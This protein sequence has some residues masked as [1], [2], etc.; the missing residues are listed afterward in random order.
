MMNW[1][2]NNNGNAVG[3]TMAFSIETEALMGKKVCDDSSTLRR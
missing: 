2:R 3:P 1:M